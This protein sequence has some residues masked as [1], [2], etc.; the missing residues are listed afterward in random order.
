MLFVGPKRSGKSTLIS[1]FL[2]PNRGQCLKTTV[3]AGVTNGLRVNSTT[4]CS[5]G[6][7]LWTSKQYN[8][9]V[10]RYRSHLGTRRWNS[11]CRSHQ[12]THYSPAVTHCSGSHH[13]RPITGMHVLNCFIY[14]AAELCLQPGNVVRD[15]VDWLSLLRRRVR[16][17]E[18]KLKK[19]PEKLDAIRKATE[20]R[21][22]LAEHPDA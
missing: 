5:V 3:C 9:I 20:Q 15:L 8:Y 11:A 7:H 22:N 19:S 2:N 12:C 10:K 17:C 1:Q 14:T 4:N 13:S 18:E 6:V 16:E 21:L